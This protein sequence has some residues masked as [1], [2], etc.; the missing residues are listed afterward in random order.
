MSVRDRTDVRFEPSMDGQL[1]DSQSCSTRL[2]RN[3][4]GIR[5]ER[6]DPSVLR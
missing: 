5:L 1:N 2:A 3:A 6:R 4:E